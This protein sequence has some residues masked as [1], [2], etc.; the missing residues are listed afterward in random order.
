MTMTTTT[1]RHALSDAQWQA[2]ESLLPDN[3][4]R[5]HP[6]KD[7]RLVIDAILW[8][9]SAGAPWRDLP[10]KYGPWS[11]AYN[12]FRRWRIRGLWDRLL[13]ALHA[14]SEATGDIDWDLFCIDGS[15]ARAHKAAAGAGKKRHTSRRA[16]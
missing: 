7:H 9:L 13:Q 4:R 5:G 15:V 12:R 14:R 2:I 16:G 6:Y 10:E 11:T 1:R 8:V 3:R